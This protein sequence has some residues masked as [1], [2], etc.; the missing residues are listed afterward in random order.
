[1]NNPKYE[2]HGY[3]IIGPAK[4]AIYKPTDSDQSIIVL[5]DSNVY[6]KIQFISD[7]LNV[8]APNGTRTEGT[9]I[10]IL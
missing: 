8:Y 4:S 10:H 3:T 5:R 9:T 6:A 7:G 2:F 1:L